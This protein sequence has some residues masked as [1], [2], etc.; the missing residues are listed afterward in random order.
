MRASYLKQALIGL[1]ATSAR[2]DLYKA[3]NL[4]D[5]PT[6]EAVLAVVRSWGAAI[7]SFSDATKVTA[8]PPPKPAAAGH[9]TPAGRTAPSCGTGTASTA[10]AP[11]SPP[12]R[13]LKGDYSNL[14]QRHATTVLNV[15]QVPCR[16]VY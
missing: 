13:A 1:E 3:L 11:A 8:E 2:A 14:L 6:E 10:P 12:R 5:K 16:N 15:L 9:R 4:A 7:T